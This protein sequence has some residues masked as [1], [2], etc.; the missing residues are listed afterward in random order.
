MAKPHRMIRKLA[1]FERDIQDPYN[2][3]HY[4]H[5]EAFV[6][7]P[8]RENPL[9]CILISIRNGHQKLFFRVSSVEEIAKSFKVPRDAKIRMK[10]ALAEA[11]MEADRIEQDYKLIFARRHLPEGVRLIREDTGEVVTGVEKYLRE[12]RGL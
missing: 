4:T 2:P 12:Q 6:P 8:D 10:A 1:G 5:I 9:P 3:K 7:L 11:N